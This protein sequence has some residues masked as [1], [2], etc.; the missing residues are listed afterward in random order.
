MKKVLL[1][2]LSAF[3][4]LL[5]VACGSAEKEAPGNAIAQELEGAPA[6]VLGGASGNGQICG[7]GSAGG[8]RNVS[9]ARTAAIGRGRT[10]LSR[11]L[12]LQVKSMLKDYQATTTGG[13]NYGTAAND[14]QH[15][16]DVSKQVT[17]MTL[18]GTELKNTW[19]SK[20]GTLFT[21]VCLNVDK[22]KNTI[23]KMGQ[24][25]EQVRAAIVQRADKA[26]DEL[27]KETKK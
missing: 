3:I 21:L 20:K 10:D 19:L 25:D 16:V 14:E 9:I 23:S 12:Q 6:W 18:N 17:Q 24:L 27:D 15:I 5:F 7:V 4:A 8:T 2:T 1:I 13:E 11:Q 22:F 26:F